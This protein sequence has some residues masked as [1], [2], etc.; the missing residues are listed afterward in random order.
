M[1]SRGYTDPSKGKK[2]FDAFRA[3]MAFAE[4]SV[5]LLRRVLLYCRRGILLGRLE[6]I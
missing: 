6:P 4:R 1:D 5:N 2:Y 3:K